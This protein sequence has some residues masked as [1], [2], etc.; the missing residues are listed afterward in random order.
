MAIGRVGNNQ[1]T[2]NL[3]HN[4]QQQLQVQERLFEQISSNKR[5]LKPSD[6]PIGTSQALGL[7]D[8]LTRY[9]EYENTISSANVWTNITATALDSTVN[10][11]RRI[12]ELGISAADGT[13][14]AADRAGMAEELEQLLQHIVQT[15]NSSHGGRYIFSGSKTDT[16]AFQ[17]E[18]DPNNGR[19]TKVFFQGDSTVRRVKTNDHGSTGLNVVGSNAG[20]PDAAGVFID[21][22][23]GVDV[24][25]TVIELRD[26]L[27]N[28]DTIGLSG[29]GGVLED[30]EKAS[31]NL[32]AAEVRLGG[33]QEVLELD[34]NRTIEQSANVEQF[35]ADVEDADIAKLILELNNVQNVYE[36]ALAAGGRMLQTG[37]LNYI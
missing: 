36:A 25:A 1:M 24:F 18:V 20:D 28:N 19:V 27:L 34:R 6:D 7:K 14:T 37:L 8:Q 12:N 16:P 23:Q 11:W 22:N 26:K 35:L 3:L 30:I 10:T 32:V 15:A 9:Q 17:S 5:I 2:N 29:A 33:T 31:R 13:K 4:I 21:S